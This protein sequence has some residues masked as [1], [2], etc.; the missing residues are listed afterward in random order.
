MF[1]NRCGLYPPIGVPIVKPFIRKPPSLDKRRVFGPVQKVLI[2]LVYSSEHRRITTDIGMM[3]FGLIA[4]GFLDRGMQMRR[5][6]IVAGEFEVDQR[7]ML[8]RGN[9]Y[10]DR[11]DIGFG[12]LLAFCMVEQES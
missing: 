9:L 6:Q 12:N 4:V 11:I 1:R 5:I 7:A 10:F 2:G 8:N 3:T